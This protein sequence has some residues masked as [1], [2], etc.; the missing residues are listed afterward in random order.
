MYCFLRPRPCFFEENRGLRAVSF[1]DID[2]VQV[3]IERPNSSV[4]TFTR[5]SLQT[6]SGAVPL[7]ASF[8][9]DLDRHRAS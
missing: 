4:Q 7:T 2:D 5:L 8:R 9:A 6:K 3:E 1:D